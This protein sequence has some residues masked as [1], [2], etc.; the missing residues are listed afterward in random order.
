MNFLIDC[1]LSIYA[2]L[3]LDCYDIFTILREKNIHIFK[4]N[5]FFLFFHFQI[6]QMILTQKFISLF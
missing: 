6:F 2:Y 1:Y 3:L 5:S 4:I